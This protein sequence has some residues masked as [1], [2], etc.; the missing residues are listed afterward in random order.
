MRRVGLIL[1]PT[2][3]LC[4]GGY[5]LSS[6]SLA[7]TTGSCPTGFTEVAAQ[8]PD[9]LDINLDGLVCSSQAS[10]DGNGIGEQ[11]L[12]DNGAPPCGCPPGFL[13]FPPFAPTGASFPAGVDRN[14][15]ET[16][17]TRM[18]GGENHSRFVFI[19]DR[20]GGPSCE[21]I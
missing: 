17:C 11:L 20:R 18:V 19:D 21:P 8:S 9:P 3:A 14:D 16:V 5:L 6:T 12:V 10:V 7:Q 13:P 15:N 1:I 4:V 2:V